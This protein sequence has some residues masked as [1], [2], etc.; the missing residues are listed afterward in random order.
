MV[1][2]FLFRHRDRLVGAWGAGSLLVLWPPRGWLPSLVP[3]LAGLALRLWARRHIGPH[4]RGR[5]LSTEVKCTGG[6]YRYLAH[7]LYTANLLVIAGVS[8]ML[9][10]PTPAALALV[11]G[12]VLL[13]AWL[14]AM[15]G[16]ALRDARSPERAGALP[17]A[18]RGMRSEWASLLP[19]LALWS[20]L[21]WVARR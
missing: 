13:Y 10:G 4:S 1:T 17:S 15:E 21:L 14:A 6:P 2:H 20:S 11:G 8:T 16:K 18:E 9:A 5:I 7:P 12:P 3:V 19:P